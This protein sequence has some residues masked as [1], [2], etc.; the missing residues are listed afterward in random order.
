M[1]NQAQIKQSLRM[2]KHKI[3]ALIDKY[4]H[5]L[6]L[7]EDGV[8][9]ASQPYISTYKAKSF[10]DFIAANKRPRYTLKEELSRDIKILKQQLKEVV[11][12]E[13]SVMRKQHRLQRHSAKKKLTQLLKERVETP[14]GAIDTAALQE[15]RD[16][17]R[18]LVDQSLFALK[19][20]SSSVAAL[21][22]LLDDVT[23]Y[24]LLG[25]DGAGS[26]VVQVFEQ[27][28]ISGDE[29]HKKTE[30]SF[31]RKPTVKNYE[32]VIAAR[33]ASQMLG[34]R[35]ENTRA[36]WKPAGNKLYRIARGDSLSIISKRFYGSGEFWDVLF[37]HNHGV[38]GFDPNSVPVGVNIR[39]P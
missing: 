35:G 39:I 4:A 10:E 29:I 32:K 12:D 27:F 36:G 8:I 20:N 3:K 9:P 16:I 38:I 18:H 5:L 13:Y 33:A 37:E 24:L 2:E 1:E 7:L 26:L 31:R 11:R 30:Q 23:D 6:K 19:A 15:A 22:N 25:A 21:Q 34:G 17:A 28:R 14:D